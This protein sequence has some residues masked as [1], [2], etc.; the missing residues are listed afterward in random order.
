MN[1]YMKTI[2]SGLRTFLDENYL[3]S[4]PDE[5]VTKDDIPE[6]FSGSWDDI[7]D[8]PF[9]EDI[10]TTDTTIYSRSD[11]RFNIGGTGFANVTID[12]NLLAIHGVNKGDLIKVVLDETSVI[13]TCGNTSFGD[14]SL[15]G[16]VDYEKS[17]GMFRVNPSWGI[18]SDRSYSLDIYKIVET[19]DLKPLDEKY[20]PEMTKVILKSSTADS[21][22]KFAITVDDSGAIIATEV[23]N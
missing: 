21:I 8:K 6:G 17:T 9:Y 18:Q 22:K 11:V 12:K 13:Y 19:V 23:A 15:E 7:V 1:N 14:C 3:R 2:L 4:V 5:Y 16:G 20:L 10:S